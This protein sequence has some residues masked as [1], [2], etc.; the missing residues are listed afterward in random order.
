MV[1]QG[2]EHEI[3]RFRREEGQKARHGFKNVHI[4]TAQC[5][6]LGKLQAD[7]AADDGDYFRV[8][9]LGLEDDAVLDGTQAADADGSAKRRLR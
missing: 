6:L 9:G 3:G 1:G 7:K 2:F 4:G 8:C 5:E